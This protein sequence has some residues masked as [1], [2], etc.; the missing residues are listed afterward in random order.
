MLD[1]Q[2]PEERLLRL[3]KE[4]AK[5]KKEESPSPPQEFRK[6]AVAE[7]VSDRGEESVRQEKKAAKGRT[8]HVPHIELS[9]LNKILL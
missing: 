3:I 2:M 4:K 8:L 9:A 7:K 6:A 1:N 5:A